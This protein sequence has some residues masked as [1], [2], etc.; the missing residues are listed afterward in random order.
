MF[1]K[2]G[3]FYDFIINKMTT[4]TKVSKKLSEILTEDQ[5]KFWLAN[6]NLTRE[7]L[8][9]WYESF[10]KISTSNERLSKE[11]F[12]K[13]YEKLQ[14]TKSDSDTFLH[15]TFKGKKVISL[16]RPRKKILF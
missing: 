16:E 3:V 12:V 13:F 15:L 2:K 5:I 4:K 9:E 11:N 7:N 10:K 6:S 1:L 8:L 14:H